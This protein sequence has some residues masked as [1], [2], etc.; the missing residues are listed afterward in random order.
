[1]ERIVLMGSE[2]VAR[3]GSTIQS[4]AEE[5]TRAAMNIEA[6]LV[7][8]RQWMDGW[9]ERFAEVIERAAPGAVTPAKGGE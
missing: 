1:M 5:M 3:A 8:N 2:D 7:A 6:A 4:A 9:L